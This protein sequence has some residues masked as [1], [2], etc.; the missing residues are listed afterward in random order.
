[1]S[2]NEPLIGKWDYFGRFIEIDRPAWLHGP[3][4]WMLEPP[5]EA[6][7]DRDEPSVIDVDEITADPVEILWGMPFDEV[8]HTW[9]GRD[10]QSRAICDR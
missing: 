10:T 7:S 6:L 1:M 2:S 3:L 9:D 8:E 4:E 5:L